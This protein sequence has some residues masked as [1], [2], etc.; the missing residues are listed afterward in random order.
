MGIEYN[1]SRNAPS[2]T[3]CSDIEDCFFL[4][5]GILC[6]DFLPPTYI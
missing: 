1:I 2:A 6:A 4:F 3:L 5:N